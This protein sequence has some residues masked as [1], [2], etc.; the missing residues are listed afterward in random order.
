MAP[1]SGSSERYIVEGSI[2]TFVFLASALYVW[3]QWTA[4]ATG[5]YKK[6]SSSRRAKTVISCILIALFVR[7]LWMF[8]RARPGNWEVMYSATLYFLN[9]VSLCVLFYAFSTVCMEWACL[10][11]FIRRDETYRIRR[12]WLIGTATLFTTE[13][14]YVAC[15]YTIES[16]NDEENALWNIDI[17]VLIASYFVIGLTFYIYGMKVNSQIEAAEQVMGVGAAETLKKVR[18]V[19]LVCTVIFA[20]RFAVW[21]LGTLMFD[22]NVIA[23]TTVLMDI[24]EI[25]YP[26]FYYTIPDV[27]PS[28]CVLAVLT[29]SERNDGATA[30]LNTKSNSLTEEDEENIDDDGSLN[31][32]TTPH[33]SS[34]K[35]PHSGPSGNHSSKVISSNTTSGSINADAGSPYS[36]SRIDHDGDDR[37]EI[38]RDKSYRILHQ[39]PP[40]LESSR[41]S[42]RASSSQHVTDGSNPSNP[43]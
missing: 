34:G 40:K 30:L 23:H 31:P 37:K 26:T 32:Q 20:M 8:G 28:V 25:V 2:I 4:V 38:P 17:L 14:V 5:G 27:I 1:V 39:K 41:S 19:A 11:A 36:G 43:N 6:E 13:A 21:L 12:F 18:V 9:R 42:Q 10:F 7:A 22:W 35:Q 3:I 15:H 16:L 29:P 33:Q 24:D